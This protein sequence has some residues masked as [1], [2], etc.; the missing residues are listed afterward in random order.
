MLTVAS[1]GLAA[2]LYSG[3]VVGRTA[4]NAHPTEA[5]RTATNTAWLGSVGA[6]GL[7]ATLGVL[8]LSAGE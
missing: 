2:G 3:A 4:W 6:A 7:S 5:T 1:G 8:W